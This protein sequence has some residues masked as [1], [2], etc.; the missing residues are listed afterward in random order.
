[1]RFDG[2]KG[3]D[4]GISQQDDGNDKTRGQA[5]EKEESCQCS[6]SINHLSLFDSGLT[7]KLEDEWLLG[8]DGIEVLV[9]LFNLI[10]HV[11][12]ANWGGFGRRFQRRFVQRISRRRSSRFGD[13]D[14]VER[15]LNNKDRD[16]LRGFK[17]VSKRSRKSQGWI[18][19]D[20]ECKSYFTLKNK[21]LFENE[22]GRL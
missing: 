11:I 18:R 15:S 1:M 2:F 20:S 22:R 6:Q 3:K 10:D 12:H 17:E 21:K 5:V 7:L 4:Q 14:E 8:E 16:K 9:G 13:H 19:R